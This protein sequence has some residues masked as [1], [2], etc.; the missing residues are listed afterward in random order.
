MEGEFASAVEAGR[1]ISFAA[2]CLITAWRQMPAHEEGRFVLAN[3]FV[4]FALLVPMAVLQLQCAAGLPYLWQWGS[5]PY[6]MLTVH[7]SQGLFLLHAYSSAMPVIVA[8]WLLLG[9]GHLG[10]AWL[11]LER[12]WAR[13]ARLASLIVGA[14]ATLVIFTTILFVDDAGVRLQAAL[15]AIELSTV[16]A[17]VRWHQR[18]R[19]TSTAHH[20]A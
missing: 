11:V 7:G 4:A 20:L 13:I 2:G 3:H 19:S 9:T 14:S 8:L 1:P 10:L 15:L 5:G 16:G 6:A 17:L 12:D 18:L